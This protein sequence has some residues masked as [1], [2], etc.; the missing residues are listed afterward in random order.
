VAFVARTPKAGK[1]VNDGPHADEAEREEQLIREIYGR[2]RRFAAVVAPGD[3]EPDDL[4]QEALT[5]AL[6]LRPLREYDDL[7]AYLCRAMLHLAANARRSSGRYRRALER[8]ALTRELRPAAYPSDIAMLQALAPEVRAV[9]YLAEVEQ[10]T[11]AEIGA[12]LGCTEIAARAR[13]SRGRRALRSVLEA[14]DG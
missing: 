3:V 10:W 14:D 2:L 8:L 1:V 7:A 11:F 6:R 9:L 5:R 12:L 4:V 13:A